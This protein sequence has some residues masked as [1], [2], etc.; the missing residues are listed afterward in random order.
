MALYVPPHRR[1]TPVPLMSLVPRPTRALLDQLVVALLTGQCRGAHARLQR[2][3]GAADLTSSRQLAEPRKELLAAPVVAP[4][5]TSP[6]SPPSL[7][8]STQTAPPLSPIS[9][10][11]STQTFTYVKRPTPKSSCSTQTP[12]APTKPCPSPVVRRK[13]ATQNAPAPQ[14]VSPI[15]VS[16]SSQTYPLSRPAT[17]Q[18]YTQTSP[19]A[20]SY[21]VNSYST[22]SVQTIKVKKRNA[23]NQTKSWSQ[24]LAPAQFLPASRPKFSLFW[25]VIFIFKSCFMALLRHFDA[26]KFYSFMSYSFIIVIA[27]VGAILSLKLFGLSLGGS[28]LGYFWAYVWE[29]LLAG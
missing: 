8:A 27:C 21:C 19:L 20:A 12:P 29:A 2:W 16:T 7:S 5:M 25:K 14:P 18:L 13:V 15:T 9:L 6:L 4:T 17:H 22:I 28:M 24:P 3:A 23:A 11:A 10:P 26:A 1:C